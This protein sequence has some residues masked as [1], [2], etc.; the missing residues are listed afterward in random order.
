M[1]NAASVTAASDS[2]YGW[3]ASGLR[4]VTLRMNGGFWRVLAP[5]RVG[6]DARLDT[7]LSVDT[8]AIAEV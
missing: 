1:R 7:T 4:S 6:A 8:A 5:A 2:H 3:G